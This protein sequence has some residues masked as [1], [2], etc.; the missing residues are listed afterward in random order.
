MRAFCFSRDETK[1]LISCFIASIYFRLKQSGALE[2][3]PVI[4]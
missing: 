1:T 3:N 4:S 2:T